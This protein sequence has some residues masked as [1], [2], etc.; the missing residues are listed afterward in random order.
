M[1]DRFEL[2]NLQKNGQVKVKSSGKQTGMFV[3]INTYE[4]PCG[5]RIENRCNRGFALQKRLHLK[6]CEEARELPTNTFN[7]EIITTKNH[8]ITKKEGKLNL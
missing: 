7:Y 4:C 6:K 1:A 8:S 3:Y 5:M 2:Q